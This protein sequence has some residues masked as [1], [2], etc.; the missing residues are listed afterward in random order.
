MRKIFLIR[1]KKSFI[2]IRNLNLI[3]VRK[4]VFFL[5]FDFRNLNFLAILQNDFHSVSYRRKFRILQTADNQD[6]IFQGHFVAQ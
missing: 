3:I 2:N 4:Q 1:V 5:H 6:F